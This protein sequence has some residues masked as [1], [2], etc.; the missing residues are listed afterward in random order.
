MLFHAAAVRDDDDNEAALVSV[1]VAHF[2]A[3]VTAAMEVLLFFVRC[4]LRTAVRVFE[5]SADWRPLRYSAVTLQT[6]RGCNSR[7]RCS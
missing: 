4:L 2:S 1:N 5:L 7:T 3:A 6:L